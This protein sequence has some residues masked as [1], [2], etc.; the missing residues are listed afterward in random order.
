MKYGGPVLSVERKITSWSRFL[1]LNSRVFLPETAGELTEQVRSIKTWIPYGNGRAYNCSP[2]S[3]KVISSERLN[4]FVKFDEERGELSVEAGVSIGEILQFSVPRGWF[5]PVVPGTKYVTAG[6]AVAADIHGKNHHHVGSISNWVKEIKL[7]LPTG[8]EITCSHRENTDLFRATCGGMG[9][10]GFIREVTFKLVKINGSLVE[11]D[12]IK[13]SC[14]EESLELFKEYASYPFVVSWLDCISR[15]KSSGRSLLMAGKFVESELFYKEPG[16]FNIKFN[17]PIVSK[18]TIKAFNTAYYHRFSGKKKRTL[19]SIDSFFFPLDAILNWNRLYGKKG[20]LQYQFVVPEN[21]GR[22]VIRETLKLIREIDEF[23]FLVVLK[24]LGEG[25][26]NMLSFPERGYTL[27]M[28]FR[29]NPKTVELFYKIDE[30]VHHHG[31]RI[32][33]AKNPFISKG[34]LEKGY[35][36][37]EEFYHIREKFG[38]KGRVESIL[39][40]RIGI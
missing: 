32:Y 13:G 36:H 2:L 21:E 20:P 15:G 35:P 12:L 33:L 31:G 3:N 7:L 23:P 10:T 16:K 40:R 19:Q 17:V 4:R 27:A 25:N 34:Y 14:L 11:V 22:T 1:T 26:S 9:L 5:L 37:L 28:D 24:L 8:E 38:L 30:I 39:S 18:W 29:F 6:G